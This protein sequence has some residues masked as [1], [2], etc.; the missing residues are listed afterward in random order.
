MT[1]SS[2]R[3]R[4]YAPALV[5]AAIL[6]AVSGIIVVDAMRIEITSTYGVGPT[7]V[8][9]VIAAGLAILGGAH[10]VMAWR[11]TWPVP[12]PDD[13]SPILMILGG[14]GALI[15]LIGL[16]GGFIPAT[17][18][19]FAATATAFGRRA[20]L[21]DL[22]IG[23]VLAIVVFLVFDKLLTLSLPYGPIER[24]LS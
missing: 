10:L 5:V 2:R 12:E 22:A 17:A 20:I 23:L 15:A 3:A 19:L 18:V 8:P 11:G 13:A 7:A 21:T 6:F 14:F 4:P 1:A 9:Y 24:L 16:G